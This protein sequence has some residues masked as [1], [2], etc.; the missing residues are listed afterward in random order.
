MGKNIAAQSKFM[1]GGQATRQA[2]ETGSQTIGQ[3]ERLRELFQAVI[4]SNQSLRSV[5]EQQADAER[6]IAEATRQIQDVDREIAKLATAEQQRGG[7]P[8]EHAV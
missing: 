2:R 3:L 7:D 8:D 6:R 4:D 1:A 5:P